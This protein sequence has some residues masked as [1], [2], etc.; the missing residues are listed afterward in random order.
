[1]RTELGKLISGDSHVFEPETLWWDHLAPKW[2]EALPRVYDE[3]QGKKGPFFRRAE[4]EI[5][6]MTARQKVRDA[7]LEPRL[8]QAGT[9]PDLRLAYQDEEGI[10]AEVL[11]PTE[12]LGMLRYKDRSMLRDCCEVYNDWLAEFCSRDP[13]R[14]IGTALIPI[15][16][17]DWGVAELQRT[18]AKGLKG[19]MIGLQPPEEYPPY[20]LPVYDRFWAAAQDI[21]APL[22]L[23]IVTGR[24]RSHMA[25]I[26][27]DERA[28]MPMTIISQRAEVMSVL[29]RDFIYGGVL[30]RFPALTLLC[31]EFEI[32]WIP[33]FMNEMD[34]NMQRTWV[35]TYGYAPPKLKPS[36]YMQTR[37]WHGFI[38]DPY[39][40]E[41]SPHIGPDRLI[42]GSDFPHPE[43]IGVNAK[44]TL[45]TLIDGMPAET[46]RKATADNASALWDLQ[47]VAK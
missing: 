9:D 13:K 6:D 29:A 1:M 17:V 25:L 20:H 39:V 22:T 5:I 40:R 8:Q 35:I 46:Q 31:S 16:D 30:D 18:A 33:W 41:M 12:A 7:K 15:E 2:G 19:A 10:G 3:Y 11:N 32:S 14:L 36:E 37:V 34:R 47:S 26:T 23:H 42:W 43:G 24:V 28:A 45:A 38:D 27:A 44:E 21:G 4:N